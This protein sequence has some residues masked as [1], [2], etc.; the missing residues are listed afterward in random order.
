MKSLFGIFICLLAFVSSPKTY[1]QTDK[2]DS[3]NFVININECIT[4]QMFLKNYVMVLQNSKKVI[5]SIDESVRDIKDEYLQAKGIESERFDEV[6]YFNSSQIKDPLFESFILI[7]KNGVADTVMVK[8]PVLARDYADGENSGSH[9]GDC[10]TLSKRTDFYKTQRN[11][12]INDY[13][14]Q[15]A[16]QLSVDSS[17]CSVFKPKNLNQYKIELVK[18]NYGIDTAFNSRLK[19]LFR[20]LNIAPEIV[21]AGTY[22]EETALLIKIPYAYTEKQDTVISN[23]IAVYTPSD[24]TLAVIDDNTLPGKDQEI[25]AEC[26]FWGRKDTLQFVVV[27]ESSKKVVPYLA[28]FI[29]KEGKNIFQYSSGE[30]LSKWSDGILDPDALKF[31]NSWL[32]SWKDAFVMNVIKLRAFP[33]PETDWM[34]LDAETV[35]TGEEML[36]NVLMQHQTSNVIIQKVF[37]AQGNFINQKEI[38]LPPENHSYQNLILHQGA[39]FGINGFP[40]LEVFRTN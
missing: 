34:V 39:V 6:R 38:K 13:L 9:N 15:K 31:S 26:G 3:A 36:Y 35:Y 29:Q 28:V 14:L 33:I 18:S 40:E 24:S 37:D 8:D 2:L 7:Y 10:L 1:G 27:R 20:Q 4:C 5:L 11:I 30:K 19:Y 12:V 32:L 25:L 22:N 23:F 16:V 21:A 17:D